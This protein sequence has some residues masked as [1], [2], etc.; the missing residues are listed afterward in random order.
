MIRIGIL[1]DSI[2]DQC[3]SELCQG[4]IDYFNTI[5]VQTIIIEGVHNY[6]DNEKGR[7]YISTSKMVRKSDLKGLI[8]FSSFFLDHI[9]KDDL[10]H[11]INSFSNIPVVSV[12]FSIPG[13]PSVLLN[14][15]KSLNKL[16]DYLVIKRE[17]KHF[18][19]MFEDADN[20]NSQRRLEVIRKRFESHDI[21]ISDSNIH[22][23]EYINHK[24]AKDETEHLLRKSLILPEAIVCFDDYI[25]LGVIDYLEDRNISVPSD[26]VV[27]G[28]DDISTNS[29]FLSKLITVKQPFLTAG[30]E[31]AKILANIIEGN[32]VEDITSIDCSEIIH[33]TSYDSFNNMD[34]VSEI[35]KTIDVENLDIHG[36]IGAIISNISAVSNESKRMLSDLFNAVNIYK[37]YKDQKQ[38]SISVNKYIKGS[39]IN[40]HQLTG[41]RSLLKKSL[42]FI[43]KIYSENSLYHEIFSLLLSKIND[44]IINILASES[45]VKDNQNRTTPLGGQIML[46]S[47]SL[48]ELL[49]KLPGY[50]DIY[51]FKSCFLFLYKKN[52][53]YHNTQKSNI[54]LKT[55]LVYAKYNHKPCDLDYPISFD[56]QNVL[57]DWE[58]LQ[59][60]S[61]Y[62][63]IMLVFNN[64]PVGYLFV[65]YNQKVNPKYFGTMR[66][67]LETALHN[68]LRLEEARDRI[69]TETEYYINNYRDLKSTFMEVENYYSLLIKSSASSNLLT[70][71][72]SGLRRLKNKINSVFIEDE[73]ISSFNYNQSI[74]IITFFKKKGIEL[75]LPDDSQRNND[76]YFLEFDPF[77]LEL[78]LKVLEKNNR[79][80]IKKVEFAPEKRI[81]NLNIYIEE[82]PLPDLNNMYINSKIG[83]S[84]KENRLL[85]EFIVIKKVLDSG[86]IPFIF[87]RSENNG[88]IL[89][90]KLKYSNPTALDEWPRDRTGYANSAKDTVILI[91]PDFHL[92]KSMESVLEESYNVISLSSA[93]NINNSM[94][95]KNKISMIIADF[96]IST[97]KNFSV[98]KDFFVEKIK[99]G[100]P[101]IFMSERRSQREIIKALEMGA[102]DFLF[103]PFSMKEVVFK[104][105]NYLTLSGIQKDYF[106][107]KFEDSLLEVIDS[108]FSIFD[109]KMKKVTD[110]LRID[111]D[112][113]P[114][115]IEVVN[116][117][118]DK[119]YH[120]QIAN[121]MNLTEQTVKNISHVI[122]KKCNVSGKKELIELI[123]KDQIYTNV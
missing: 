48:E 21:E 31:S 47:E 123:K 74:P 71:M 83:S 79:L 49:I 72:G 68:V 23:F 6:R 44:E 104:V 19:F 77:A 34:S 16:V 115:E 101:I 30:V 4:I 64:I 107:N 84:S 18:Y 51:N 35:K 88:S 99:L 70:D 8:I 76:E 117:M 111:Y 63:F 114:R 67:N 15:D 116:Y 38:I 96:P 27:T 55:D 109:I 103:K 33:K 39:N 53:V 13:I 102:I 56:S 43:C 50:L 9:K 37:V 41:L 95:F 40:V 87:S 25:A 82:V 93:L 118:S 60:D 59:Y 20:E 121:K 94:D 78:I 46:R 66:I 2:E 122:Y 14:E 26:I 113:T 42:N 91:E 52:F 11:F 97:S 62:I 29:P 106:I 57:P 12:G 3:E 90:I 108:D 80:D 7:Q 120:R 61:N 85:S 119:L 32:R 105:K 98:L 65:D 86:G 5:K 110:R 54:P 69:K 1:I 10:I 73:E 36:D 24:Q 17:I 75:S 112:L 58:I 22:N 89:S 100:I 28:F 45:Y 92:R 81:A